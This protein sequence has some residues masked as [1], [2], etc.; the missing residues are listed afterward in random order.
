MLTWLDLSSHGGDD[1]VVTE[2]L[3]GVVGGEAKFVA[4]VIGQEVWPEVVLNIRQATTPVLWGFS[5]ATH[6]PVSGGTDSYR[7]T[8]T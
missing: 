1:V 5:A 4:L 7:L 2:D 8:G 3:V 6:L